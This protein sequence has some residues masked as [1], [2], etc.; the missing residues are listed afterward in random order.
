MNEI[1]GLNKASKMVFE[2][3]K[4]KG[5]WDK[6]RETGTLLMLIVSEVAETLEADRK[7]RFTNVPE[8]V[9]WKEDWDIGEK[10][11]D[12]TNF[13]TYVKDTFEDEIADTF[14]RLMDLCGARG[15]DIE[16]HI[17]QKL[18]YNRTRAK[19]HGKNY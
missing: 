6:E 13:E 12:V 19:K 2:D 5:F 1:Q 8:N 15:I 4:K 9:V 16:W 7:D 11:S 10:S 18:A 14:I 17:K 3:N